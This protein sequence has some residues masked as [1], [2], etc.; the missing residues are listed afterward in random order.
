M[1]KDQLLG[2]GD[3]H[4]KIN[5]TISEINRIGIENTYILQV[6]DFGIGFKNI[7]KESYRMKFLN[8]YLLSRNIIMYAI[9]G[10]H[11][12]PK[13]FRNTWKEE[14]LRYN[15]EEKKY[16]EIIIEQALNRI[17]DLTNIIFVEDYSVLE[18]LG[19]KILCVGGAISIDRKKRIENLSWWK[20]EPLYL[21]EEKLRNIGQVDYLCLH[22]APSTILSY[23]KYRIPEHSDMKSLKERD[24]YLA[25][26]M[27]YESHVAET[28]YQ[29][30]LNQGNLTKFFCGHYHRSVHTKIFDLQVS[31][32]DIDEFIRII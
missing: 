23:V 7:V 3:I 27:I 14:I 20:D 5:I 8:D 21:N 13:F 29:H 31:V 10:N 30:V 15:I 17:E 32:I 6:G 1:E 22:M 16:S 24:E 18:I 25:T 28:I 2:L 26:D 19:K 4:G 9:R 12:D 11:D